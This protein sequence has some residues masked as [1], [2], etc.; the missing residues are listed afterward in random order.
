MTVVGKAFQIGMNRGNI[1]KDLKE[2]VDLLGPSY[3]ASYEFDLQTFLSIAEGLEVS[4][5]LLG[6]NSGFYGQA[7]RLVDWASDENEIMIK[8]EFP[9]GN[10][11][12]YDYRRVSLDKMGKLTPESRKDLLDII[13]EAIGRTYILLRNKAGE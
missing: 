11:T 4:V 1:L 2:S 10:E 7:I 12:D 13:E 9:Y 8:I 6:D 3:H 5:H